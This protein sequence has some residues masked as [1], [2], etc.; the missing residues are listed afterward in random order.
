MQADPYGHELETAPRRS[1][2]PV[3]SFD[4]DVVTPEVHER[5]RLRSTVLAF[6]SPDGMPAAQ[7]ARPATRTNIIGNSR[8]MQAVLDE[9]R[10]VAATESTVLILGET[11]TG[12]ELIARAVHENSPRR[13]GP[14]VAINCAAI[15]ANL[16]ESELFGHERGA[17]TGA[18]RRREGRFAMASGG[19]LFLD[20][21]GELPLDLQAKLLRVLQEGEFEP[22]GSSTTQRMN[23]RVLA[24]THRNLTDAVAQGRFREDLFY[25]LHVLPLHLPPLRERAGD[26]PALVASFAERFARQL[27]K[28]TPTLSEPQLLRLQAYA[29]PG[30]VR[31]LQNVV[32]RAVILGRNGSFEPDRYVGNTVPVVPA[33]PDGASG[34][35]TEKDL[36]RLE[37]D[38]I[39]RALE[40]CDWQ[41]AGDRGAARLLGMNASTLASRVKAL[42]VRRE[43]IA[44]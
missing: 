31:E 32:E 23:A 30:N 11:G 14:M 33:T 20:E 3:A 13:A 29:W 16:I 2:R 5:L 28:P 12:K 43:S 34:I 26:I 39:V 37:R 27:G 24:A 38:N 22:V 21:I 10:Q 7:H 25:R 6:P 8:R 44:A 35:L 41:I 15:P 19:T 18:T 4:D 36:R 9:L 1:A 17:F 40:V 42:G